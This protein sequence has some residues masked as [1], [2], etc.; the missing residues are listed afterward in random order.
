MTRPEGAQREYLVLA[1]V[2]LVGVI[3]IYNLSSDV[4]LTVI[5]LVFQFLAWLGGGAVRAYFGEGKKRHG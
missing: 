4:Q 1:V 2:C 5:T 3:L